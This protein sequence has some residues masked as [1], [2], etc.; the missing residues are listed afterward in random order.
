MHVDVHKC[1]GYIMYFDPSKY[2]H[3]V[4]NTLQKA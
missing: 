3:R 1:A 4:G 2:Y